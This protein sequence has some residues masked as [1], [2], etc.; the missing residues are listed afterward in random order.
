MSDK[1]FVIGIALVTIVILIGAIFWATRT[2]T[3]TTP[4]TQKV[5]KS[6]SQ[7]LEIKESDWTRGSSTASA[8][9]IE[10][11]DFQCPA[12]GAYY[13]LVE[14]LILEYP[15]DLKFVYRH[16]PL[17][18]HQYA[19]LAAAAAEAAGKQEKF[20]Q[21]YEEIF[22]G[23]SSWSAKVD[24]KETFTSYAKSLG[25]DIEKFTKDIELQETKDKIQSDVNDGNQL[26]VNSTP[27]FFLNGEKLQNP[28]SYEDFATLVR[29][30]IL[31]SPKPSI[32][33]DAYHTH[34][35]L[36][37]VLDTGQA[38]DFAQSKYQSNKGQELDPN[39]H[40]HDGVGD[41]VHIHK[42]GM[43]LAD[44]FKSLKMT[45]TKDCLT[46][47]TSQKFCNND[48]ST[49]RLIVNGK[50]NSQFENLAPQDLDRILVIYGDPAENV[51]AL[52]TSVADTACIYSEK[53]PERG[54]P[55]TEECVGGLGTDC[56]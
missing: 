15:Q 30:A 53:C 4:Q 23:Q 31:K 37:V 35:N 11:S 55:P 20:W 19:R 21:M 28:S 24:A 48:E 34:F 50:E 5:P 18:Q 54:T 25:L 9:L 2:S 40:F 12:C 32:G 10:Y 52:I 3:S 26:G 56:K 43:T 38:I 49:L 13:P 6:L 45:F 51:D 29:S 39:I 1:K 27:T 14:Q 44:L 41:L 16:F 8:T 33:E 36:K 42:K 47:D 17:N 22:R 7:K 46:L